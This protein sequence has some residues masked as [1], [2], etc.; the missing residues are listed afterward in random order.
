MGNHDP[1]LG[2]LEFLP[3]FMY[4]C[5]RMQNGFLDRGPVQFSVFYV[6]F[7]C[8]EQGNPNCLY[9][10]RLPCMGIV[11][12]EFCVAFLQLHTPF[13]ETLRIR[14]LIRGL[15][16]PYTEHIEPVFYVLEELSASKL[17]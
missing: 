13:N 1:I 7:G 4:R 16:I 8:F 10:S 9:D 3:D 12:G 11:L 2:S 6:F 14:A 15:A 5:L 17:I